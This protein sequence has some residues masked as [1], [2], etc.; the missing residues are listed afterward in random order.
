MLRNLLLILL[1]A[2]LS[3]ISQAQTNKKMVVSGLIVKKEFV[4]KAGR[5][6]GVEELYFRLSVQDYFIKFCSSKVDRKT[7]EEYL[8]NSSNQDIL[9]DKAVTLEIEILEGEWDNCNYE[10]P[11]QSR[12]GKYVIIHRIVE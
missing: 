9:G 12:I 8:E 11:V 3:F 1:F 7:L 5:S 2:S 4:N 6:S 10:Y